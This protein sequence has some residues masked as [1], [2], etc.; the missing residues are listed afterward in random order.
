MTV[1]HTYLLKKLCNSPTQQEQEQLQKK[2]NKNVI[3]K[4]CTPFTV[5]I[6]EIHNSQVNNAKNNIVVMLMYNLTKSDKNDSKISESL[7]IY[8]KDKPIIIIPLLI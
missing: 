8:C 2:K 5:C 4:K 7:W 6:N 1:M 3:F